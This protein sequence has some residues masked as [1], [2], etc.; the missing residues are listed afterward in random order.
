MQFLSYVTDFY[1]GY[2]NL[3]KVRFLKMYLKQV[4][5]TNAAFIW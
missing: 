5:L 2:T 1:E 3:S 4:M